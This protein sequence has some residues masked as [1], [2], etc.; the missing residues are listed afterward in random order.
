MILFVVSPS[1]KFVEDPVPKQKMADAPTS[2][3]NKNPRPSSLSAQSSR[4]PAGKKRGVKFEM[5][6]DLPVAGEVYLAKQ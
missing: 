2:P 1:K 6:D 3:K 5:K 4:T